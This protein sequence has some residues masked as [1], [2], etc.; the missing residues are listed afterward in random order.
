M[1]QPSEFRSP[2]S[3]EDRS[4]SERDRSESGRELVIANPQ[5]FAPCKAMAQIESAD[6]P[7]PSFEEPLDP[8][9][10]DELDRTDSKNRLWGEVSSSLVKHRMEGRATYHPSCPALSLIH[11]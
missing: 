8:I 11:I 3:L 4:E 7:L 6:I 9:P 1:S 2:P 5:P 10:A